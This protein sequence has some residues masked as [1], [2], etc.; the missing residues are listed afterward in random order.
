MEFQNTSDEP[1][2]PQ[3]ADGGAMDQSMSLHSVTESQPKH[4]S[5]S[6]VFAELEKDDGAP[7]TVGTIR[8]ALAD[9]SFAALLLFFSGINLLPLPPGS[10]TILGVPLII[11]SAQ[12]IA[13]LEKVWLPQFIARRPVSR[14]LLNRFID[15]AIPKLLW[16]EK[17]IRPRAWPFS[18]RAADIAIGLFILGLSIILWLPIPFGGNWPPALGIFLFTLSLFERDGVFFAAGVFMTAVTAAVVTLILTAGERI[19]HVISAW[20]F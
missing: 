1:K 17:W 8:D 3:E 7:V 9:R 14:A 4:R 6:T 13:G 11:I 5:L 20:I 19:F 18:N 2:Y 15:A 16:L 10:T 12:M